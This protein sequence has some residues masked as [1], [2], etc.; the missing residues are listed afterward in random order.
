MLK[1]DVIKH[2][3]FSANSDKKVYQQAGL[4]HQKVLSQHVLQ[5]QTKR[6]EK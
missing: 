1:S 6:K 3:Q 4:N 5:A 2:A